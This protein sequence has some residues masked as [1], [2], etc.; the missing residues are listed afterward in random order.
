V[1]SDET[2]NLV[3]QLNIGRAITKQNSV[4]AMTI[5]QLRQVAQSHA[6]NAFAACDPQA[7]IAL[8]RLA[9]EAASREEAVARWRGDFEFHRFEPP[10]HAFAE[11]LSLFGDSAL[12]DTEL[13]PDVRSP[14]EKR[15]DRH[16][17]KRE[18]PLE[19]LCA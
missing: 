10:L 19:R 3:T 18:Q 8:L 4:I 12:R 15:N 16:A 5:G 13:H 2:G 1:T 7:R 14:Q 9:Q 6:L 17:G 11:G